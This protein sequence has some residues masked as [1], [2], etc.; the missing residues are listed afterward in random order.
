MKEEEASRER[1]KFF[2]AEDFPWWASA[3]LG[4]EKKQ[5]KHEWVVEWSME[6]AIWLVETEP[7]TLT[8]DR[9]YGAVFFLPAY[10][11]PSGECDHMISCLEVGHE[12]SER[13]QVWSES[14]GRH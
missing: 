12:P 10:R 8:A 4:D 2:P 1:C 3:N 6:N 14:Q 7:L 9:R 11:A 13:K 5:K